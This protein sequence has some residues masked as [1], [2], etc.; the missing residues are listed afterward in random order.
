MADCNAVLPVRKRICLQVKPFIR[1]RGHD[2]DGLASMLHYHNTIEI[3]NKPSRG[4][5][6]VLAH[7]WVHVHVK[8]AY[9][10]LKE[11]DHGHTFQLNAAALELHLRR[12]G[13]HICQALYN[14]KLDD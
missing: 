1:Y 11:G 3:R 4:F 6:S 10:N 9:P 13:W 12:T 7:E 2:C 14:E 5:W 8:E